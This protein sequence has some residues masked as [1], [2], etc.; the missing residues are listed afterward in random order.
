MTQ[1]HDL[2]RSLSTEIDVP[3]LPAER[4]LD[5]GLLVHVEGRGLRLVQHLDLGRHD[6]D[7][8]G[9][10]LRVLRSLRSRPH[11]SPNAEDPFVAHLPEGGVR[12][13]VL[14]GVRDNLRDPVAVTQINECEPALVAARVHPAGERHL[15]ARKRG[16]RLAAGMGPQ[17]ASP[18]RP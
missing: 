5:L 9:R 13:G 12:C 17:H 4:L 15:L 8:A 6:L 1:S 16:A 10:K 7:V 18:D 2:P 14:V 11:R 3:V